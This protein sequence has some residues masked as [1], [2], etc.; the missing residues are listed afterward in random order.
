[1]ARR[2]RPSLP[3][4]FMSGYPDLIKDAGLDETVFAKPFNLAVLVEAIR[5][6]LQSPAP[7]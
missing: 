2:Q 7:L 4:I 6:H 1:M 3:V 5:Q